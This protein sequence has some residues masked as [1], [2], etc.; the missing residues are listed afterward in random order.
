[1]II[2]AERAY[3][4]SASETSTVSGTEM[5]MDALCTMPNASVLIFPFF[6]QCKSEQQ[7]ACGPFPDTE[8]HFQSRKSS[9]GNVDLLFRQT[10]F[11]KVCELPCL[12]LAGPV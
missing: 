4:T 1:M 12:A 5:P 10:H 9:G 2:N 7:D 8:E 11:L 3:F 6:P